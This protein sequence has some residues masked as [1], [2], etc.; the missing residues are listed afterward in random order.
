MPLTT[1]EWRTVVPSGAS[2]LTRQVVVVAPPVVVV[3]RQARSWASAGKTVSVPVKP[4]VPPRPTR[5][6]GAVDGAAN[7]A[8]H[9][10]ADQPG[11]AGGGQ[12]RALEVRG[13]DLLR[14]LAGQ[15]AALGAV[16]AHADAVAVAQAV[17]PH[18]AAQGGDGRG[19][20]W[21]RPRGGG[22][23]RLAGEGL[24][25]G[26]AV[27]SGEGL[28]DGST[29][30]AGTTAIARIDVAMRAAVSQRMVRSRPE[31]RIPNSG[32]CHAP[33]SGGDGS[34]RPWVEG[35]TTPRT[36]GVPAC[37]VGA[38]PWRACCGSTSVT[39]RP[40]VPPRW[41]PGS[42]ACAPAGTRRMR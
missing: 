20:R 21:L 4:H 23:R 40:A 36:T 19:P 3:F 22:G 11:G 5:T 29:A 10:D 18:A 25:E 32:D 16:L 37:H 12:R 34:H 17:E 8:E 9:A 26:L 31:A 6:S 15:R 38:V 27:G 24:G 14:R 41:L 35:A 7:S 33:E 13:Q 39:A 42:M 1:A 30:N 2:T 28:G